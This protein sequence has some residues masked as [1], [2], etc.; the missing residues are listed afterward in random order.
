M[1]T[2]PTYKRGNGKYLVGLHFTLGQ[3]T[4]QES[5]TNCMPTIALPK[6]FQSQK[7]ATTNEII[8]RNEN[9]I[10]MNIKIIVQ[11]KSYIK[12]PLQAY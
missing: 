9:K 12:K 6:K 5:T 3:D 4:L 7:W 8:I 10:K 1:P 2:R 11:I